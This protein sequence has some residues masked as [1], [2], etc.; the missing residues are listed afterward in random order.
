MP[1]LVADTIRALL[2][3]FVPAIALWVVQFV[4]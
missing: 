1:F 3:L 2:V 4:G